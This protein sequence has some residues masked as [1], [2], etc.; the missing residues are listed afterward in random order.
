ML[1]GRAAG[2]V[3]L[4]DVRPPAAPGTRR[5]M[6]EADYVAL[7]TTAHRYLDAPGHRDLGQPQYA[8]EREMR[9]F[10]AGHPDWLT[11]IQVP[12]Y[13]PDLNPVEG[14][15]SAMK[16][17]TA[18]ATSP[19]APQTS[20]PPPCGTSSTASSDDP[21]SLMHSS[22]RPDSPSTPSHR[23]PRPFK[24]CST[25]IQLP[26]TESMQV[27]ASI[28]SRT[29]IHEPTEVGRWAA[30][31]DRRT[32][33]FNGASAPT[34]TMLNRKSVGQRAGDSARR[35]VSAAGFFGRVAGWRG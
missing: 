27:T 30:D 32:R 14:A 18:G 3:L 12:A 35:S 19:P 5:A 11:V 31:H 10:T 7:I 26:R 23:R 21:V 9:A 25:Q 2:P 34:R 20:S 16:R 15:W 29:Q 1:Q 8:P 24:L 4:P 17:R 28:L 6:S 33:Y 22:A 13:A